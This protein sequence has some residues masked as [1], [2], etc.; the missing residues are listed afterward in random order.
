MA[1]G[2]VFWTYRCGSNRIDSE[3]RSMRGW[4]ELAGYVEIEEYTAAGWVKQG[5]E[6]DMT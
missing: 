3:V 6:G 4:E 1:I 5:R 2:V